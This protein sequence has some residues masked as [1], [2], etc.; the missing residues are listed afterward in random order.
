[1]SGRSL[2]PVLMMAWLSASNAPAAIQS[3]HA[4]S[5]LVEQARESESEQ[6]L[7]STESENEASP[8]ASDTARSTSA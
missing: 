2:W 3:A 7:T 6:L 1:M 8:S 5:P 4:E